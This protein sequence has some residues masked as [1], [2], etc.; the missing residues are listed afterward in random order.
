M[1]LAELFSVESLPAAAEEQ[2]IREQVAKL[3]SVRTSHIVKEIKKDPKGPV[4]KTRILVR[5]DQ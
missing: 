2:K 4:A 5:K 3:V 1:L